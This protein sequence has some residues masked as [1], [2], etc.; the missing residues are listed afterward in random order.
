MPKPDLVIKIM[1]PACRHKQNSR[2]MKKAKC[3]NCGYEYLIYTKNK[4]RIVGIVEGSR[5]LL[6]RKRQAMV[7]LKRIGEME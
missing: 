6:L 2:S 5:D 1:C 3:Q 7:K 4:T